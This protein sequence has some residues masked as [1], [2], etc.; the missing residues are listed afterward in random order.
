[1]IRDRLAPHDRRPTRDRRSVDADAARTSARVAPRRPR[2]AG[3]AVRAD[4]AGAGGPGDGAAHRLGAAAGARA[5]RVRPAGLPGRRGRAARRRPQRRLRRPGRARRH[6]HPR[7]VRR[8]ADRR[9]DRHGRGT[10]ATRRWWPASPTSPRCSSRSGGAPGWPPCTVRGRLARRAHPA[11]LGR[12]AAAGADDHRAG[13]GHPAGRPRRPPRSRSRVGDRPA[14]RRQPLPGRCR[15]SA[16][17]T[18]PT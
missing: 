11:G 14:A 6:L 13:D 17:P 16:P 12:V 9:R 7:R 10:R 3:L 2:D 8:A 5:A 15:R 1:M 18:C 4:Q